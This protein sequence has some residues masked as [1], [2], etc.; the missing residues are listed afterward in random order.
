MLLLTA[1]GR[2]ERETMDSAIA[3]GADVNAISGYGNSV[4][5]NACFADHPTAIAALLARGADPNLRMTYR[6]PVDG[7]VEVGLVALMV[8]R[9]AAAVETLLAAGADPNVSDNHGSTPLMRAALAAGPDAVAMLPE[10]RGRPGG[11]RRGGED[12]CRPGKAAAVVAGGALDRA[13][14]TGS[15]R[16]KNGTQDRARAAEFGASLKG[17]SNKAPRLT[18]HCY[19]PR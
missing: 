7:R 3:A 2:G 18:E 9:S 12:C 10:G 8:C 13:A 14:G 15:D 1:A 19:H 5:Y 16:A 11:Q 17:L 4:L 6:S